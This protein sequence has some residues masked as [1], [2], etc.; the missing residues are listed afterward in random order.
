MNVSDDIINQ[1]LID[2][3]FELSD[4][5]SD[6]NNLTDDT[7]N[8]PDFT[9]CN[10]DNDSH[11]THVSESSESD[12]DAALP[13]KNINNNLPISIGRK[14]GRPRKTP[15]STSTTT[16]VRTWRP[17]DNVINNYS[18]NPN[19]EIIGINPDLFDVLLDGT[20]F[21]FFKLIVSDEIIIKIVEETNNYAQQK[22]NS[23]P[24]SK[25]SRLS[26]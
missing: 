23:T 10:K 8:D 15:L 18:F 21:D 14:P 4:S 7:Y 19:S 11:T 17:D 3:D 1:L 24:I 16:P 26:K 12:L 25:F 13:G 20:P 22:I 9:V 2:S 6:E 5:D